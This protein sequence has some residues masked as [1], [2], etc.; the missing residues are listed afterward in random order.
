MT[1]PFVQE[2]FAQYDGKLRGYLRNRVCLQTGE[3]VDEVAQRT[4]TRLL[5][6]KNPNRIKKPLAYLYTTAAR[7]LVDYRAERARHPHATVR[8]Y[9]ENEEPPENDGDRDS[10]FDSILSLQ[11]LEKILGNLPPVYREV[12]VM[13][14]LL[15]FSNASIGKILGFTP[16]TIATYHS[17]ALAEARKLRDSLDPAQTPVDP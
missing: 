7:V 1:S 3:S 4:W 5:Q 10:L 2:D 8:E 17:E 14:S 6:V 16:G 12:I 9:S 15:G 13:R 11:M